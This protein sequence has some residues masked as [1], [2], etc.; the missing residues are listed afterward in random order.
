[1]QS[2][3]FYSVDLLL[4]SCYDQTSGK[5]K[6]T[7]TWGG[8]WR[9]TRE[10]SWRRQVDPLCLTIYGAK[11]QLLV[12]VYFQAAKRIRFPLV[13][14]SDDHRDGL[15]KACH[16]YLLF[17]YWGFSM[18]QT[19]HHETNRKIL[20]SLISF[21]RASILPTCQVT[22]RFCI[23]DCSEPRKAGSSTMDSGLTSSHWSYIGIPHRIWSPQI[24]CELTLQGGMD[25][26][27]LTRLEAPM[28]IAAPRSINTDQ[29]ALIGKNWWIACNCLWVLRVKKTNIY[30]INYI[31]ASACWRSLNVR[32]SESKVYI[33]WFD[34]PGR[35]NGCQCG[36]WWQSNDFAPD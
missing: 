1:M 22:C 9:S 4:C 23:L 27:E 21:G 16:K 34:S 11:I 25:V 5:S 30:Y 13:L 31:L 12:S 10:V 29:G 20:V 6:L 36:L 26:M 3:I 33:V 32:T 18:L 2:V 14:C 35:S 7:D 15:P 28:E 19:C 17:F 8:C 24:S